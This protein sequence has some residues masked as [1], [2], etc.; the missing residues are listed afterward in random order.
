M[1]LRPS[2]TEAYSVSD[3][4]SDTDT[5]T[6]WTRDSMEWW[7]MDSQ[8]SGHVS[9]TCLK[10]KSEKVILVFF[11]KMFFSGFF[12]NLWDT[13]IKVIFFFVCLFLLLTITGRTEAIIKCRIKRVICFEWHFYHLF[14]GFPSL[15]FLQLRKTMPALTF[16]FI[17]AATNALRGKWNRHDVAPSDNYF[18][19]GAIFSIKKK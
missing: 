7:L 6:S 11:K 1:I 16:N 19:T 15:D 4:V 17:I 8:S 5:V 13:V 14:W 10:K 3:S 18:Y 9:V 12:V 2:L